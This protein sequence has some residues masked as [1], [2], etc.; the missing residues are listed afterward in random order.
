MRTVLAIAVVM[1]MGAMTAGYAQ[2][3]TMFRDASGKQVRITVAHTFD[4]CM[5]NGRKLGY[6]DTQSQSYCAQH[7]SDTACKY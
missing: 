4:Q 5:A 1:T 7:C 3:T 6:P 2:E